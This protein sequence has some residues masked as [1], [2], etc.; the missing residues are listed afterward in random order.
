MRKNSVETIMGAVVVVVAVLF[1]MFAYDKAD[2]KTVEGYAVSAKFDRIDG[3]KRGSDVRMSGIKIGTVTDQLLDPKS[4]LA[5]VQLNID[6]H[7]KLPMD[8]S[9]A[10]T[11]D[12]LLGD[13]YMALSPGG[14]DNMIPPG[15]EIETTQGSIDLFSLVGQMIFSQT[16]NKDGKSSDG[17][18]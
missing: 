14:D 6:S 16:G 10:I 8:T 7:V 3:I 9:A 11:S 5:V 1:V 12:G 18:K 4:Y 15:G 13:K 17:A 2:L